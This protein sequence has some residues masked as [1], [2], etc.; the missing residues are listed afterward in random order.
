M[1]GKQY[2]NE[3][4]CLGMDHEKTSVMG[5]RTLVEASSMHH[6]NTGLQ[7]THDMYINGS[8]M[9]LFEL[10][11]DRGVSKRHTSDPENGTIRIEL[12]FN[13]PLPEAI[14]CLF[15][16]ECDNSVHVDFSRSVMT[17]F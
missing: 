10:T 13:K 14:T 4:L 1:N 2:P 17:D 3:H 6:W 12:K 9:L 7:I 11:P 16:P 8:F 15:Y 5:Y